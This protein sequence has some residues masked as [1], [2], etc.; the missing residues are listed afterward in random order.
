MFFKTEF[1]CE[2]LALLKFVLYTRLDS[3]SE[4]L[5]YLLSAEIKELYHHCPVLTLVLD[6][7][8]IMPES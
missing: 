2:A 3:N 8:Y 1:P 4:I 7:S 5:L 6:S